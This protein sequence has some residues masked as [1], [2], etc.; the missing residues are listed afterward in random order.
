MFLQFLFCSR[1]G[2][3]PQTVNCAV[4][5]WMLIGQNGLSVLIIS[6][7]RYQAVSSDVI[8]VRRM[9]MTLAE[10]THTPM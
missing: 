4:E 6:T 3:K 5:F 7:V 9:S 2:E 10:F 1:G 8:T